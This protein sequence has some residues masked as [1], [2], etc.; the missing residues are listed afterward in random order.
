MFCNSGFNQ[1]ISN[2][3]VSDVSNIGTMFQNNSVFNQPLNWEAPNSINFG[4]MFYGATNFNRDIS[5]FI[6]TISY[7][8]I[9]D[10]WKNEGHDDAGKGIQNMFINSVLDSSNKQIFYDIL[11][12]NG[13]NDPDLSN[14]GLSG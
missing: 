10:Y 1:D 9:F 5:G 11:Y 7:D 6:K 2:W 8:V 13:F 14:A 4:A 12:A 3:N